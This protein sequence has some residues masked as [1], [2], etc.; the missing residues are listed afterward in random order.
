MPRR[1]TRPAPGGNSGYRRVVAVAAGTL[2]SLAVLSGAV[3]A[4]VNDLVATR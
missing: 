1:H 4:L 2:L 3:G